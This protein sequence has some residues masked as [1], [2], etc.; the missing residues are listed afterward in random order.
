MISGISRHHLAFKPNAKRKTNNKD[1]MDKLVG[2]GIRK[3]RPLKPG[4]GIPVDDDTDT[5]EEPVMGSDDN[6]TNE[7]EAIVQVPQAG[8]EEVK[9]DY[10]KVGGL[11]SIF[12]GIL[13]PAAPSSPPT[14]GAK[15]REDKPAQIP[16]KIDPDALEGDLPT[17]DWKAL[18]ESA[19]SSRP[20][21]PPY[22]RDNTFYH[23]ASY[24]CKPLG[25]L[26]YQIPVRI[27]ADGSRMEPTGGWPTYVA[28]KQKDKL[29]R[30]PTENM[31]THLFYPPWTM[32]WP[33]F[34]R[35]K[36]K[37][38]FAAYEIATWRRST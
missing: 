16:E 27:N 35:E 14:S 10:N 19:A 17:D 33:P 18:K 13:G 22:A 38:W 26:D 20:D 24:K 1:K 5:E 32:S 11:E 23:Q 28:W 30:P 15:G 3:Q 8:G 12:K 9:K 36:H 34:F 4:E 29:H 31:Q 7:E 6:G 21:L 25:R 2:G 37:S